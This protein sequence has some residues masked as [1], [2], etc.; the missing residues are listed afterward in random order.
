MNELSQFIAGV[1]FSEKKT[2]AFFKINDASLTENAP[3]AE[4]YIS[5]GSLSF[6]ALCFSKNNKLEFL[7][8]CPAKRT[9]TR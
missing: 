9:Y 1:L 8:V 6:S 4:K 7:S 3:S 2:F 5:A